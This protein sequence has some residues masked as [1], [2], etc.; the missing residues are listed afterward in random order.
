MSPNGKLLAPEDLSP[1]RRELWDR[2]VEEYSIDAAAAP[3]LHTYCASL[4][5]VAKARAA[6]LADGETI[7]DRFG[8]IKMSPWA[9]ILRDAETAASRAFRSLG[10]DQ[11]PRGGAQGEL[12]G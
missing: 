3:M 6:L 11:E 7:K 1:A 9:A 4:D 5:R 2:I 8:V 10:F 12:F